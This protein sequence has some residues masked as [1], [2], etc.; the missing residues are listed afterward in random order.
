MIKRHIKKEAQWK[1][2]E[3]QI[4]FTREGMFCTGLTKGLGVL[5]WVFIGHKILY[6]TVI[7]LATYVHY[8]G[9][10]YKYCENIICFPQ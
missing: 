7:K 4:F 9:N 5:Y 2:I 1:N 3:K 6:F 10:K 8:S